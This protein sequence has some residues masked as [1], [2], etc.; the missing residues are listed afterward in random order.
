MVSVAKLSSAL[1]CALPASICPIASVG[2]PSEPGR[3][4]CPGRL[5]KQSRRSCDI[6]FCATTPKTA[7]FMRQLAVCGAS[8]QRD[9]ET[10][11]SCNRLFGLS[12]IGQSAA[13]RAEPTTPEGQRTQNKP[14][15]LSSRGPLRSHCRRFV[16][17]LKLRGREHLSELATRKSAAVL[18][19]SRNSHRAVA[20]ESQVAAT[21]DTAQNLACGRPVDAGRGEH[22]ADSIE[23]LEH[24]RVVLV[25][26]DTCNALPKATIVVNLRLITLSSG[27]RRKQQSCGAVWRYD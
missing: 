3:I 14:L 23:R 4:Q 18:A 10:C 17:D 26:A 27:S 8:R 22:P 19:G 9:D 12:A 7:Q 25:G 20:I 11:K 24:R 2:F 5:P 1:G 6:K 21:T 15:S 13:K 16:I